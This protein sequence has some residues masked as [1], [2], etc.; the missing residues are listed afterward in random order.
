M[1]IDESAG[2]ARERLFRLPSTLNAYNWLS[3]IMR[4]GG[5]L[6]LPDSITYHLGPDK[7]GHQACPSFFEQ[8]VN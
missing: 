8:P 4:S 3:I 6:N 5:R 1:K 2:N 7:P